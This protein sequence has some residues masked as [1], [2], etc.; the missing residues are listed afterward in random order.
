MGFFRYFSSKLALK[1]PLGQNFAL[2]FG[3]ARI[4]YAFFINISS[5]TRLIPSFVS[6]SQLQFDE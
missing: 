3:S 5:S 4:L 2:K 6:L 1:N